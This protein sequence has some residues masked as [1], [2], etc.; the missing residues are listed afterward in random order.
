MYKD[1]NI[2]LFRLYSVL[3]SYVDE[4]NKK[5]EKRKVWQKKEY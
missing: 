4:K 2:P 3:L 5:L 1:L